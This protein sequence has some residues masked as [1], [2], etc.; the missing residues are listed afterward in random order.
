[1]G[2]ARRKLFVAL[3]TVGMVAA[4][5]DTTSEEERPPD[6]TAATTTAPPPTT[7][8]TSTP[9]DV[10][11]PPVTQ[12]PEID[13]S[14]RLVVVGDDGNVVT[15]SP[16][17]SNVQSLTDDA[18]PNMG[19][20]QPTW[21]P[22]ASAVSVSTFGSSGFSIVRIDTATG[23]RKA[24][25]TEA[26][27]FYVYWSPDGSQVGYLST[28][29]AGMG[30]TLANF[31]DEAAGGAVDLGQPFYFDWSPDGE[32]LATLIGEQRLDVRD[33]TAGAAPTEI[34]TPGSFQNPIWTDAG[35]IYVR[36]LAGAQEVVLGEPDG[37][38]RVL[39]VAPAPLIMTAPQSGDR[40]ALQA[41]GTVDGVEASFQELPTLPL[42]RL[43][44][45]EVAT[46]EITQVTNEPVAAYFWDPAGEKLLVLGQN[47]EQRRLRWSLWADGE[48]TDLTEFLPSRV[49]AD[50]YLPF[51][52]QYARS[53]TMWAPDGSSFAF[54]GLIDDR[55][56]I[57]V[58]NIDGGGPQFVA[59][60]NWVLWSPR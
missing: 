27:A 53:T 47:F 16:D 41:T 19:Y 58:Q 56:G 4:A 10:T 21:S 35:L 30:L 20:F 43:A 51:F 8:T 9:P 25:P 45:L 24:V 60:G 59:E 46:G 2:I 36:S 39:A 54:P 15:M 12:A 5:C 29:G 57:Y 6:T 37:E 52:G 42:N 50:T 13:G 23:E 34:A 48:L 31:D 14:G 18:A 26:N 1:M 28:G 7:A 49:W 40:V 33:A 32:Q 22:D 11:A 44:V 55:G 3:L 38:P 17:G